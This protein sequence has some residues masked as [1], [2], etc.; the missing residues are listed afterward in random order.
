MAGN[1]HSGGKTDNFK[2]KDGGKVIIGGDATFVGGD[3]QVPSTPAPAKSTKAVTIKSK[4]G[5][6]YRSTVY[7]SWKKDNTVRQ[8]DY[9]YG[10]CNGIWLFGDQFEQF[11]GKNITK[12]VITISRQEGGS[13]SSVDLNIKTHNYKTRPSGK[14]SY[15][16]TVGTLGLAVNTTDKK[17]ITDTSNAIITGLK[18]GTIK[19]IGLQSTYDSSHYAVCSGSVT[20]KITYTE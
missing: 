6:T 12:V 17:T 10:D 18:A 14:P 1:C 7:D 20:I 5:D 19:G 13:Y 9:G 4:S 11:K 15:V 16:G 8:G 3:V 2:E